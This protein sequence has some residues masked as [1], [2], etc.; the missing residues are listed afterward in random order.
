MTPAPPPAAA[1]VLLGLA[2]HAIGAVLAG[3][4]LEGWREALRAAGPGPAGVDENVL[5]LLERPGASFVTL[6]QRGQLRGCIGSL[7]AHRPLGEDVRRNAVAAACQDPRF[8]PLP[9]AEL[10]RTRIEVSVLSA[11]Q[12]IEFADR[13]DLL[14]QLRPGVDG[15]ILEAPGHRGTFLPQVWEQLPRPEQFWA[16]LVRKAYLPAGYWSDQLRVS[17]YCVT[18]FE[19]PPPAGDASP[20]AGPADGPA[21]GPAA[22]PAP[23]PAAGPAAGRAGGSAYGSAAG[24]APGRADG[25]ADGSAACRAAGRA[26]GSAYGLADGS[27]AGRADGS[28]D[29]L[30]DGSAAGRADGP[31]DGQA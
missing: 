8:E 4:R 22:G 11:P 13:P 16:H 17:R 26:D 23:G 10:A 15:L 18:A 9:A 30:A 21:A 3:R 29:G 1:P 25:S 27:A 5:D 31:A 14:R 6:T 12:P 19:E 20:A 24:P 28:A 2:R 7:E